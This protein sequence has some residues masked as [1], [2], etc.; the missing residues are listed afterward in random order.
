MEPDFWNS[1]DSKKVVLKLNELKKIVSKVDGFSDL[2]HSLR[3]SLAD[4]ELLSIVAE[5]IENLS[6]EV[7]DFEILTLLNKE[8]DSNNC[9]L[10]I[11]SGAGGTESC[12][13]VSMLY[14]MYTR[15]ASKKGYKVTLIDKE[16]GE[17]VGY[18]S[19][20]IQIEGMYAYG[21]L[22]CERGVHRLVRISPFDS[23]KRRHTTFASVEVTPEIDKFAL[24][25]TEVADVFDNGIDRVKTKTEFPAKTDSNCTA[26]CYAAAKEACDADPECKILCDLIDMATGCMASLSIATA[27]SLIHISEPTR[28]SYI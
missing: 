18:K 22:K 16:P 21:Y 24:K 5:E 9:I 1:D 23:N 2:E 28:R 11:H 17:E 7:N 27:L 8:A 10:E 26:K 12:D 20:S 15:Y 13:W 14:R 25:L 19:I 3:E 6:K 4:N